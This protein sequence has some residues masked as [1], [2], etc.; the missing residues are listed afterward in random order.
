MASP[1][2]GKSN[3]NS[4][5]T[6]EVPPFPQQPGP[7]VKTSHA[8]PANAGGMTPEEFEQLCRSIGETVAEVS[9]GVGKGLAAG[10]SALGTAIGQVM[11]AYQGHA[12]KQAEKIKATLAQQQALAAQQQQ[13]AAT[14]KA[15]AART[16]AINARFKGNK[17]GNMKASGI[18]M[19]VLGGIFSAS[20]SMVVVEELAW[21]PMGLFF[22]EDFLPPAI[23]FGLSLWLLFAGIGRIRL[24]NALASIKRITGSREVVSVQELAAQMQKNPATVVK[25]CRKLIKKGALPQGHMDDGCT[26]LMVTDNAY[27]YY[28]QAQT[29]EQQR[30]QKALSEQQ[31]RQKA[32]A[33][34][35]SAPVQL[36]AEQKAFIEEGKRYQ[37]QMRD[38][39]TAIDDAEV[40]AKIVAIETTVGRILDRAA[41]EP[42]LIDTLP[43]FMNYYLPTTVKLLTAYDALEEQPV[44]GANIASS[45]K[46]IEQTLDVLQAA[47]EKQLDEMFQDMS[48]DVASD[49]SVLKAMLAQEGL[50]DSP[51]KT[52]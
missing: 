25:Q 6:Y 29:E 5:P 48:M 38:L 47:Y 51:F 46:D 7:D 33:A 24:G 50:T 3:H 26:C 49:I 27:H 21:L 14:K 44:Q 2:N 31:T 17:S 16:K 11:G 34:G 13:A 30:R 4:A 20:F 10:G 37:Q 43:R 12:S 22:F 35:K 40:S 39:D 36:T 15:K 42:S 41:E 9:K 8:A 23:L 1:S 52:S 18:W 28:R 45:R 19:T 32:R